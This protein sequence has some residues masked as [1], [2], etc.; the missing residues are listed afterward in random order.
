MKY[1]WIASTIVIKTQANKNTVF[2]CKMRE[3]NMPLNNVN[4]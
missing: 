1:Y 2:A 4:V 3:G